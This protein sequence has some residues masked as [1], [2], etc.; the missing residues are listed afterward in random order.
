MI[1]YNSYVNQP[2]KT[3]KIA[4]G[5][6]HDVRA[7]SAESINSSIDVNL[8]VRIN[9]SLSADPPDEMPKTSAPYALKSGAFFSNAHT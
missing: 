9:F 3:P 1:K 6:F 2:G 4:F 8:F 7:V 5:T